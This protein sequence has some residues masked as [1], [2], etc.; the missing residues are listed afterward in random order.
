MTRTE[1]LEAIRAQLK[2]AQ[3][4]QAMSDVLDRLERNRDYKKIISDGFLS[5]NVLEQASM[6]ARPDCQHELIQQAIQRNLMGA[7]ALNGYMV[8]LRQAA[9]AAESIISQ[10]QAS[11]E[12]LENMSD[13]E[14]ENGGE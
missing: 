3:E 8:S 13:E 9:R 12:E 5:K 7:S 10:C 4:T 1:Q 6:I 11:I 14:F 2:D